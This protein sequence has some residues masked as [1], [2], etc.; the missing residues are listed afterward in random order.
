[1]LGQ[2]IRKYEEPNV[3]VNIS[4]QTVSAGA[5]LS[6]HAW[7]GAFNEGGFTTTFYQT[8]PNTE[9]TEPELKNRLINVPFFNFQSYIFKQKAC[10]R[11][12]N[13]SSVCFNVSELS[14]IPFCSASSCLPS[15]FWH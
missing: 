10:H 8:V 1:M 13:V 4:V 6:V 12:Y 7:G 5:S 14:L 11:L 15:C 2:N 3:M 9:N